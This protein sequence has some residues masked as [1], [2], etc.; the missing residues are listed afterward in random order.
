MVPWIS[1]L[2][3]SLRTLSRD[4]GFSVPVLLCLVLT[5]GAAT[6]VFSVVDTVLLRPLPYPDAHLLRNVYVDI[7]GAPG[8][9]YNLSP[10][11][12]DVV[13]AETSAFASL[14]AWR[15][16]AVSLTG[17]G[18]P[19]QL[20]GTAVTPD[21]F[22]TLSVR[23]LAGGG[24]A[25]RGRDGE[26]VAYL[27]EAT[28][29]QEFGGDPGVVG[30]R[31]SV[32]DLPTTIAG[33]VD[34]EQVFPADTALWLPIL[35]DHVPEDQQ[36]SGNFSVIARV[37]PE[38]GEAGLTPQLERVSVDLQERYPR[39]YRS[40]SLHAEPLRTTIVGDGSRLLLV[41]LMAVALLLFLGCTNVAN[42]VLAR[43]R[44]RRVTVATRAA[45]GGSRASIVAWLTAEI[46]VVAALAAAGGA[47]LAAAV[48]PS[49]LRLTEITGPGI[50]ARILDLRTLGF[51][52]MITLATTLG[53]GVLPAV[54][55]S[56]ADLAR[57]LRAG[58]PRGH[59][60]AGTRRARGL[61]IAV[62]AA[63]GVVLVVAAGQTL[64]ELRRLATL[65]PGFRTD[66]LVTLRMEAPESRYP[67]RGDYRRL[68][69]EIRRALA[70]VPGVQEVGS[71]TG[72]PVGDPAAGFSLSVEDHP[73]EDPSHVEVAWGR[74]VLPGYLEAMGIRLLS[75]RTIRE[76][77]TADA[78]PVVVVSAEFADR[79]WPGE[80]A[81]GKRIKRRTYTSD[82]PWMTVIG[83]VE[84]VRDNGLHRPIEA[85]IYIPHGQTPTGIGRYATYVVRSG[86]ASEQLVPELRARVAEV[87]P[88]LP[89][90][91]VATIEDLLAAS[92]ATRRLAGRLLG[93]F[94]CLGLVL[95]AIGTYGVVAFAV[96]H[97]RAELGLRKALGAEAGSLVTLVLRD[98][99]G[100]LGL[101]TLVG[102]AAAA[103]LSR[104]VDATLM[105]SPAPA[106]YAVAILV[107]LVV[108]LI[109][110]VQPARRAVGL[111]PT[112]SIREGTG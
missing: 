82:F 58:R 83:V 99:M 75:G 37:R 112:V 57:V 25:E 84:D 27:S 76:T 51:T 36:H 66:G 70:A 3:R 79:Y 2:R 49:L 55:A 1:D 77:D 78:E 103:G 72:L 32:D 87:D 50:Q 105:P 73:P 60:G 10:A 35:L 94:A 34:A 61:L 64:G 4:P 74:L 9:R 13:T 91:R 31:I 54:G 7:E 45:L 80:S 53:V 96:T 15:P 5:I 106:L 59:D 52:S 17:E 43:N 29:R 62:Q 86:R 19:R 40:H 46:A 92:M 104:L 101:G 39:N 42:L 28:W 102:V 24:F 33:I 90:A 109:A 12:I 26:R 23:P 11:K 71:T 18:E 111:D 97:R 38:V 21:F 89:I 22:R 14:A 98:N 67:E 41:L 95:L 48:A 44:R 65:D 107:L 16:A 8:D 47:S 88:N 81:V 100:Y 6:A 63:L 68:F 69:V 108:G 85:T 30:R 56:R 93:L 20:A 110:S